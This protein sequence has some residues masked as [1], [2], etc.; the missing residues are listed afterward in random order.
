MSQKKEILRAE[1]TKEAIKESYGKISKFYAMAEGVFEKGLRKKGLELLAIQEGETVLEIGFGT[2][3]TLC[4]LAKSVGE[5]G[6]ACG[7][8]VTPEMVE[9]TRK[10]LEKGGLIDRV[11]LYEEDGRNMPFQDNVFDAVYMA[12]TL[13][14]FD[15]PDIPKILKEIKR[16]LKP[17]GRLGVVS[18]SKE[19]HEDSLFL[20]LYE[21]LHKKIPKYA[22]C[23][24]I[25]V[26]DVLTEIS[27]PQNPTNRLTSAEIW[28]KLCPRHGVAK[29][30]RVDPGSQSAN[31]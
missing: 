3:F 5:T 6:R 15:T 2:G 11:E 20:K 21:W 30:S 28:P 26:E 10:R 29:D 16:V 4:E 24:P 27:A 9:I 13:E 23:R 1:V 12:S 14:L 17:S 31:I 22:S 19:G 7:I 25:Y 18:M 8:D